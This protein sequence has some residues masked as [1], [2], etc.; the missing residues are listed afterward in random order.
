[1]P[2]KCIKVKEFILQGKRKQKQ[3]KRLRKRLYEI[4]MHISPQKKS[5]V[6]VEELFELYVGE[7]HPELK[8][9]NRA[10]VQIFV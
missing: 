5:N 9:T 3:K 4:D 8:P 10:A 6:T 2:I 7:Y 1:M